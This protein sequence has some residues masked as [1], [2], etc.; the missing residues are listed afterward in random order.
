MATSHGA[1][2]L[3]LDSV[4]TVEPGRVADLVVLASDPTEAIEATRDIELVL[5]G[6]QV[7]FRR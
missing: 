7:A 2:A 6:G 5:V 1:A 3:G 4:G